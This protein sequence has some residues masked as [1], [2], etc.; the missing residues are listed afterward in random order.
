M[1]SRVLWIEDS[2]LA[3]VARYAGPVYTS[4]KYD[5]S[6]A[7]D[8][9]AGR[10]M[11]C[12]SEYAAVIVDIRLPPGDDTAWSNLYLQS[13]SNKAVARLGLRLLEALLS[14]AQAIVQIEG[15][16]SWLSG[17]RFGVLT[18][19]TEAEIGQNLSPD[20]KSVILSWK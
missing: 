5:L 16:P 4:G 18:V 7:L 11:I 10:H 8:A 20:V 13:R 19:E 1:R 9:T 14:R 2:A 6:V 17:D 3:E 12:D 15:I